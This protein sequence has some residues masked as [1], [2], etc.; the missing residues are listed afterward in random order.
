MSFEIDTECSCCGKGMHF[1]IQNDLSYTVQDQSSSPMFYVPIVD[2][3][4]LK[5]PSIVDV[6]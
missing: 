5:E 3:T 4:K 6:F 2:L 1:T